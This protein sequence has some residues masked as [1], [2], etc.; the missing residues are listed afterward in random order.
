MQQHNIS[1]SGCSEHTSVYLSLNYLD[2]D[3]IILNTD[4]RRF[5]IRANVEWLID[6][7]VTVGG[8]MS[9]ISQKSN[10]PYY[11][12]T[13]GGGSMARIFII[14]E[15]SSPFIW[16]FSNDCWLGAGRVDESERVLSC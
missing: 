16:P 7:W 4:T 13:A 8:R 14:F 15:T 12:F 3:G 11:L 10:E 9:Y 5:G 2:Q 6:D 1:V